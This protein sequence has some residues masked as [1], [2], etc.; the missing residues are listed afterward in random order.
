MRQ[1]VKVKPHK[2]D[3]AVRSARNGI[4]PSPPGME[5]AIGGLLDGRQ[6]KHLRAGPQM[7]KEIAHLVLIRSETISPL[8]AVKVALFLRMEVLFGCL[9]AKIQVK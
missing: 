4:H 5:T 8:P 9:V 3:H 7:R 1:G 2:L 6:A